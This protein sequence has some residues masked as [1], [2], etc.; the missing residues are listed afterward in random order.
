MHDDGRRL[1]VPAANAVVEVW[2]LVAWILAEWDGTTWRT[3]DDRTTLTGISHW[4]PVQN[5]NAD[6]AH[7]HQSGVSRQTD[8]AFARRGRP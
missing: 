4:R 7:S 3:V 1:G 8:R 6:T 5:Q 2:H